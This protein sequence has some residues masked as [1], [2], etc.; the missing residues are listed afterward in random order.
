MLAIISKTFHLVFVNINF[1]IDL[2]IKLSYEKKSLVNLYQFFF[3]L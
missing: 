1:Y 2:R 3:K